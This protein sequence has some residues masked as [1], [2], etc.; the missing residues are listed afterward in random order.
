M[1]FFADRLFD[2]QI[3]LLQ[4]RSY[5]TFTRIM[6]LAFVALGLLLMWAFATGKLS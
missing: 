1:F 4:S 3:R 6:G 5:R 2:W